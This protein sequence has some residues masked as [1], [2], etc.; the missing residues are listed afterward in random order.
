MDFDFDLDGIFEG[1]GAWAIA[2]VIFLVLLVVAGF[3]FT[4]FLYI[5]GFVLYKVVTSGK[6]KM[7]RLDGKPWKSKYDE[8]DDWSDF[9]GEDD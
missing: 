5:A 4:V 2:I 8:K 3:M 7:T 1:V 6:M 9:E